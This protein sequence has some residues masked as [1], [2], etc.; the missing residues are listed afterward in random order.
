[1]AAGNS[2]EP[3]IVLQVVACTDKGGNKWKLELT[4]GTAPYEDPELV[5]RELFTYP[6]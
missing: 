1:M 4:D 6:L 2:L 3:G 5:V